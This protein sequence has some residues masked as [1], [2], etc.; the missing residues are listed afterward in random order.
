[1]LYL[2]SLNSSF[3][4]N[5]KVLSI[6]PSITVMNYKV[7]G[8]KNTA[9]LAIESSPAAYDK[10]VYM[11]N[12]GG[13]LMCIDTDTLKPVWAV[14][15]GDS[16]MAA[17][18]LDMQ[19][20]DNSQET[21]APAEEGDEDDPKDKAPADNR[22]LNLYTANMLNNRKKGDSDI[23]IRRYNALNGK[24][25]WSTSVGV[26]KGKKDKDD[27]GAKASPVIGQNKLNDLVYFTVTGLSE[28]GR[29]KLGLSGETPAV[30]IALDKENGNIVWS[31]GLSSR[32]ES[33]PIAVYDEEGNG[34]IIQCEQ[35][36]TI[37][38]LEGLT[39]SVV[40][41]MQLNAEIEASPAAYGNTMVIGTTGKN[42]SF[43]YAIELELAQVHGEEAG[44]EEDTGGA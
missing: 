43:I 38:L 41:T 24:E 3:D 17:V 16:V 25:I 15:T 42:T 35:N 13:V 23:Q 6:D 4:Y 19:V 33:S 39:G 21:P 37:H 32:S 9:L 40:D 12:M 10:Y 18:A 2:E 30:L 14:N 7:K 26:Y 36:G 31:Y 20:R 44:Y 27:V 8:Q 22:E 11:A 5:A 1:M 29:Q 28:E 34:W